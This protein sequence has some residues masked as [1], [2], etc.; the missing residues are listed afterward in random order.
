MWYFTQFYAYCYRICWFG[1]VPYMTGGAI[2]N[3]INVSPPE[4][5]CTG[6]TSKYTMDIEVSEIGLAI[7]VPESGIDI[8]VPGIGI[9]GSLGDIGG[10]LHNLACLIAVILI[11]AIILHSLW[12]P[13][14]TPE[15]AD[16]PPRGTELPPIR[17]PP[18]FPYPPG[19]RPQRPTWEP[20]L[21][22]PEFFGDPGLPPRGR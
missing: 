5:S 12:K 7:G 17:R 8:S 11:G 18:Q 4:G 1:K 16:I 21:P 22:K 13:V 10:L 9:L 20:P 19:P 14:D 3:T 2:N 15:N 6:L